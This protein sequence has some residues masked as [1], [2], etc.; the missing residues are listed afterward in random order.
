MKRLAGNL[1]S[2]A[3]ALGI[4]RCHGINLFLRKAID[5]GSQLALI[6][7]DVGTVLVQIARV[8]K[9]TLHYDIA[10]EIIILIDKRNGTLGYDHFG[11]VMI[12]PI[13]GVLHVCDGITG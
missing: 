2:D 9:I 7:A 1:E 12:E 5:E 8:A 10:E 11:I 3:I 4:G 6:V 13:D